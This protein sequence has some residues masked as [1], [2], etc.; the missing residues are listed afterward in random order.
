MAINIISVMRGNGQSWRI[1]LCKMLVL[2]R[3]CEMTVGWPSQWL[4][5]IS[6]TSYSAGYRGCNDSES[7]YAAQK[8]RRTTGGFSNQLIG[9]KMTITYSGLII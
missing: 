6:A 8:R 3:I 9:V 7:S 5:A 2:W 4:K 1:R